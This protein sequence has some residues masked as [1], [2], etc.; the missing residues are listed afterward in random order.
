MTH[1]HRKVE[2]QIETSNDV[3]RVPAYDAAVRL[4][5]QCTAKNSNSRLNTDL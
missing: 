2:A 5:I 1:I 3:G 4:A